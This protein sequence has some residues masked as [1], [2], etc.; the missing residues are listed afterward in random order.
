MGKVLEG[1]VTLAHPN[2]S[3]FTTKFDEMHVALCWPKLPRD[4]FT[5]RMGGK[6]IDCGSSPHSDAPEER[7]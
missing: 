7:Y 1:D 4:S 6:S 5:L 2:C 3:E